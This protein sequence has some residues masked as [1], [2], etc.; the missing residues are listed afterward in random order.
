MDACLRVKSFLGDHQLCDDVDGR[1][2]SEILCF[3]LGDGA[4]GRRCLGP[5]KSGM[6][7]RMGGFLGV[8][9]LSSGFMVIKS[10]S[11]MELSEARRLLYGFSAGITMML[12]VWPGK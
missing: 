12:T 8:R 4:V 3:K 10:S 7:G 2:R 6:A 5:R 1:E 9:N 11:V